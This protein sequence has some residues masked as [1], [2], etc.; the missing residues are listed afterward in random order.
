VGQLD[1]KVFIARFSS[2]CY[3][4]CYPPCCGNAT[5]S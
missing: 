5:G 3:Q 1:P 4:V 2:Q